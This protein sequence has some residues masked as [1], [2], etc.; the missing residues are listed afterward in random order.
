MENWYRK[1]KE[2]LLSSTARWDRVCRVQFV[3][4]GDEF[5]YEITSTC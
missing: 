4:F 3:E 2:P 5:E 1:K